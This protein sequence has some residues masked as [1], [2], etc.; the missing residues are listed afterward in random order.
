MK[1]L[2]SQLKTISKTL[3]TLSK[4]VE[5]IS[6]QM[7]KAKPAAKPA[8]KAAPAKAKKV[9][10]KPAKKAASAKKAATVL[11]NVYGVIKKN[12]N[13]VNID[14]LKKQTKLEPRQLSNALYKLTK[15]G[16]IK[17]KSR[18]VYVPA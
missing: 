5:K 14:K 13:G 16:M 9:A 12:K 8:K 3:T 7:A 11:E 15:K 6:A 2:Q 1:K 4:Q 10:K 18:G 17:T